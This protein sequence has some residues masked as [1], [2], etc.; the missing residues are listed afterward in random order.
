[1]AVP[2]T[3]TS[4]TNYPS[5]VYTIT[6]SDNYLYTNTPLPTINVLKFQKT[7]TND[8]IKSFDYDTYQ[9]YVTYN[10][11][12]FIPYGSYPDNAITYYL[13]QVSQIA[14]ATNGTNTTIT[15]NASSVR[16]DYK[17]PREFNVLY[18]QIDPASNDSFGYIMYPTRLFLTPVSY[19]YNSVSNDWAL[20]TSVKLLSAQF[21]TFESNNPNQYAASKNKEFLQKTPVF[22][23]DAN[24]VTYIG[25]STDILTFDL[26]RTVVKYDKLIIDFN[27]FSSL[28]Y[29]GTVDSVYSK[30]IP[31]STFITYSAVYLNVN[32]KQ[33]IVT[34]QPIDII[35]KTIA[36]NF[37]LGYDTSTH[38]QTFQ[39]IQSL[40]VDSTDPSVLQTLNNTQYCILSSTLDLD[41]SSFK[42]YAKTGKITYV[43]NSKIGLSYIATKASSALGDPATSVSVNTPTRASTVI[44][45]GNQI[46]YHTPNAPHYYSYKIS[47]ASNGAYQDEFYLNFYVKSKI[48]NRS[49]DTTTVTISSYVTSDHNI[50]QYPLNL[51]NNDYIKYTVVGVQPN[52][53][54]SSIT[55]Y[56]SAGYS[57]N[58]NWVRYDL[59]S[60]PWVDASEARVLSV[61][62][63][64]VDLGSVTLYL[65][66]SLKSSSDPAQQSDCNQL[67]E[68]P[69]GQ[70]FFDSRSLGNGLFL[71]TLSERS[72]SIT[73]DASQNTNENVWPYR[74][75]T[76]TNVCWY[77][78]EIKNDIEIYNTDPSFDKS[79]TDNVVINAV[80]SSN[81]V[82]QTITP[83]SRINFDSYS[84]KVNVKGYGPSTIRVYLSSAKY[85]TY[86]DIGNTVG[87]TSYVETNP[88]LFDYFTEN[89]FA[90][91]PIVELNNYNQI[92]TITLKVQVPFENYLYD[93]PVDI[94]VFWEWQYNDEI[95]P[96]YQPISAAYLDGT[97]YQYGSYDSINN[98]SAISLK[99]MPDTVQSNPRTN[100]VT[101]SAY[102]NIK[103]PFII[104][105]YDIYVD[106]FPSPSILNYGFDIFY[107][108]FK[109]DRVISTT[110]NNNHAVVTRPNNYDFYFH[111]VATTDFTQYDY[112]N[113]YWE[114][115]D[116]NNTTPFIQQHINNTDVYGPFDPKFSYDL[117]NLPASAFYLNLC[118]ISATAPGWS[119]AHN[120]ITSAVF[121]KIDP[122]IFSRSLDFILYP[123]YA[124]LDD[125]GYATFLTK[126]NYTL[127]YCP[128]GY[129][130]KKS[131][132]Y[133][134]WLS[135]NGD[136]VFN[137]YYYQNDSTGD[138]VSTVS[139]FDLLP[140]T[141][142]RLDPAIYLGINI[143]LSAF[144]DTYFPQNVENVYYYSDGTTN[145]LLSGYFNNFAKTI[146]QINLN[147][148]D[149]L[150]KISPVIKSY[151]NYNFSFNLDTDTIKNNR[152][153][154]DLYS[155][156]IVYQNITTPDTI[157]KT[158]ISVLS[159]YVKYT[160]ENQYWT[161]D[162]YVNSQLLSAVAFS[163]KIGDPSVSLNTGENGEDTL[164]IA[165]YPV[166]Q[167]QIPPTTFN[168]YINTPSYPKDPDLWE[169]IT[170][171][172]S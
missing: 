147:S 101:I 129:E 109:N 60:S 46:V 150:F 45:G 59:V 37:I 9:I 56:I 167:I 29:S 79:L 28:T 10:N 58:G 38:I 54:A 133:N 7:F 31:D 113:I 23:S 141:Y 70:G 139:A 14:Y 88:Y 106:D 108:K 27:S 85:T 34:Q 86:D 127:S 131:D 52:I 123:E 144:N 33:N 98:L 136:G 162:S 122:N 96:L 134:F 153:N 155:N 138:T 118:L 158:P 143:N 154:L 2:F 128:S 81:N 61:A 146:N 32:S 41:N 16:T 120:F 115:K 91:T 74:D 165:A 75:L 112:N 102:S 160:L 26:Y 114:L 6:L 43:P 25:N 73:I 105:T 4:Q 171:T 15:Y 47:L 83:Y 51:G 121:Y 78:T 49:S 20:T 48:I 62:Y 161:A 87:E 132:S 39:L 66:T 137:Q 97:E 3:L 12:T 5:N 149:N 36:S 71:N 104:G 11:C 94:P 135:A 35:S 156:V 148:G 110:K 18:S 125:S 130:Y 99:I 13:E 111:F 170:L 68:I 166:I 53:S 90:I 63:P 126:N 151:P 72:N 80:D 44:N 65:K 30:I 142:N 17:L 163:L 92:R 168:N 145:S 107:N 64:N 69:L 24:T 119:N 152:L 84:W 159:G 40:S 19:T 89:K 100:K 82:L 169:K 93:I 67:L 42:F 55:P 117:T 21:I 140:I 22:L 157:T 77:F 95:D 50:V 116:S 1:M 76:N 172:L 124:W 8:I 103:D 164:S 57:V